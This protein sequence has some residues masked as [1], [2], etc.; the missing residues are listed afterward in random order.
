MR[1]TY[2]PREFD[3]RSLDTA[4]T[5]TAL[6]PAQLVNHAVA[7]LRCSLVAGIDLHLMAAFG[8]VRSGSVVSAKGAAVQDDRGKNGWEAAHALPS[9]LLVSDTAVHFHAPGLF[10]MHHL[11]DP[12]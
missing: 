11:A 5:R 12:Y 7:R 10:T 3:Y 8:I 6:S 2:L 9:G 1:R 4:T